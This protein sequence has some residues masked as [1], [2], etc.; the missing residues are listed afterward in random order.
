[1]GMRPLPGIQLSACAKP[2][3]PSPD[4]LLPKCTKPVPYEWGQETVFLQNRPDPWGKCAVFGDPYVLHFD[5]P[6]TDNDCFPQHGGPWGNAVNVVRDPGVYSLVKLPA[7]SGESLS[8]QGKFGYTSR[9]PI[10]SAMQG[11]AVTGSLIQGHTLCRV[12]HFR[13]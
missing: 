4:L 7:A 2:Y 9:S 12:P 13:F 6:Y 8:I 1:M 5:I 10:R 11:I 3:P